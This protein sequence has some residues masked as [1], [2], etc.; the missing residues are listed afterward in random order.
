MDNPVMQALQQALYSSKFNSQIGSILPL[1]QREIAAANLVNQSMNLYQQAG[2]A[3][4]TGGG[5][6]T[7][8]SALQPGSAAG[9]YQRSQGATSAALASLLGMNPT[10][11]AGLLPTFTE[12]PNIANTNIQTLYGMFNPNPTLTASY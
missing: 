6:L 12:N 10:Q 11:I 9:Q 3:Q 4:G 2:G 8:L 7:R 1:A 5:L